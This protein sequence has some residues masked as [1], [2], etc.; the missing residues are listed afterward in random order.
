MGVV[1]VNE[2]AHN[3]LF[4]I[5]VLR[6]SMGDRDALINPKDEE[7]AYLL[8]LKD[9][10]FVCDCRLAWLHTLRNET[11]NPLIRNTLDEITCY[12][13]SAGQSPVR[14]TAAAPSAAPR[15]V[16]G[17]FPADNEDYYE[18][19]EYDNDI[20]DQQQDS[21]LNYVTSSGPRDPRKRHLFEIPPQELPCPQPEQP[22][23]APRTQVPTPG[24]VGVSAS[25]AE[26]L[27]APAILLVAA[28]LVT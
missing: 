13:E 19:V 1:S 7:R 9:N 6:E 18:P 8:S 11:K 21:S 5:W 25:G 3:Q 10:K 27:L 26:G 24:F 15:T 17:P 14:G 16:S 12:M 2:N 28:M 4:G 20:Y 23:I 22:T